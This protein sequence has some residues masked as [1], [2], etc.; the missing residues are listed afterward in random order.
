MPP[1]NKFKIHPLFQILRHLWETFSW[2]IHNS[3]FLSMLEIWR[4]GLVHVYFWKMIVQYFRI[5]LVTAVQR[6][7]W[8]I[9]SVTKVTTD[10]NSGTFIIAR[11]EEIHNSFT[12]LSLNFIM[13]LHLLC[14]QCMPMLIRW[15]VSI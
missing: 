5:A 9:Q 14:C 11:I 4:S 15:Y 6:Q 7:Q 12:H 10:H 8:L 1:I 13:M 2:C 3:A